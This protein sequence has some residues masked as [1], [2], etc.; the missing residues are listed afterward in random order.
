MRSKSAS[1]CVILS[2]KAASFGAISR[3]TAWNSGVFIVDDQ[4]P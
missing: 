1:F 4:T 2:L 3:S